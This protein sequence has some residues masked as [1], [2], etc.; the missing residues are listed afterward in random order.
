MLLAVTLMAG[1]GNALATTP[2][3]GTI[4]GNTTWTTQNSPY[5]LQGDV[6]LDNG[7]LLTVQPGVTVRMAANAS[8]TLKRGALQAQGNA[9]APITITSANANP[10]PGDWGQWRFTSGTDNARTLLEHV[11]MEYGAGVAIDNASPV[12]RNSEFRFH[13]SAAISIDLA[14]SPIGAGNSAHDN[15]V[16]AIAVPAG[17]IRSQVIWGLV[18]IPYLVQQGIVQVGQAPLALEP[19]RLRMSPGVVALLQAGLAQPAGAGGIVLDVSS[20]VPS[21]AST[22]SRVTIAQ[23]QRSADIEVQ[24]NALGQTKITVSHA[25]LGTAETIVEVLQL[26]AMSL[27]PGKPTIGVN[28]PTPLMLSLP[29]PAPDGGLTVQLVN[30]DSTIASAPSSVLVAAGQQSVSFEVTGLV[31]GQTR[32]S[33]RA[34]G[35]ADALATVTVRGKALVLPTSVVVAPGGSTQVALEVTEPAPA[36]G[37]TVVLSTQQTSTATVPASVTIPAGQSKTVLNVQGHALGTTSLA[38]SASGYQSASASVLVDAIAIQTEPN[39]NLTTNVELSRSLRV[40]L[41]KAAPQGGVTI[42]VSSS[43]PE[44]ASVTPSELTVLDGQIYATTPITIKGISAGQ[45]SIT[46]SAPGLLEKSVTVNVQ[47]QGA[48]KLSTYANSG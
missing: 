41:S 13:S 8:F 4:T 29:N 26:P 30:T 47:E 40:L 38:A 2:V 15:A 12:I 16:N 6:V 34:E 31:D 22:A 1:T 45:A 17:T 24:A 18:G 37:L 43:D 10:A 36:G 7:A 23:D 35:Y 27:V 32:L 28:R 11:V 33:A 3:T 14:S 39:G 42:A 5:D 48:L 21:V 46:L 19:S 25:Q 9:Q 44:I 20:S